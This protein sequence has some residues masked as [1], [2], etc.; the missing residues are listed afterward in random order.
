MEIIRASYTNTVNEL[1]QELEIMKKQC[2]EYDAQN[3]LLTNELEKRS[4][5]TSERSF[6]PS[7]G[8]SFV[9]DDSIAF[10]CIIFIEKVRSNMLAQ[11]FGEVCNVRLYFDF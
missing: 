1:N 11:S 2:E 10:M 9:L 6:E 3:Q 5:P 4:A 8:M 7:I